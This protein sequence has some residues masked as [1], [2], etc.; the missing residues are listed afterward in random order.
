ML[1]YLVE[2]A[3]SYAH[4]I[5]QLV[6]F[7]V[8][9]VG[10]WFLL[11]EAVLFYF[12]YKYRWV[13]GQPA[14]YVTGKEKHLKQWIT[15]PHYLIIFCDIFIVIG[16]VYVWYHIKQDKP[17]PD[18]TV[19]IVAQ[20]WAW[21]FV[22]PGVDGQIDTED[23]IHIGDELHIVADQVYHFKLESQDVQHSF[24]VPAFRLK[25]DA[26]PGREITGWFKATKPGEYDIQC[27]EMC[28]I[29]HGLM[30]AKL[31]VETPDQHA[32]WVKSQKT[33]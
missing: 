29:G 33:I 4:M 2:P 21:S 22:H 14:Q 6:L 25:Q 7:N 17:A 1:E 24:S 28:G 27:A 30:P 13:D 16:A 9:V 26:W 12:L 31:Y 15:W 20:Q 8:V 23:D 5:D 11:T 10:F 32:D 19:R 18:Y 3:S